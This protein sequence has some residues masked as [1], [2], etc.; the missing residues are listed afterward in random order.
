MAILKNCELW[1]VKCDPANPD[2]KFEKKGMWTVQLRTTDPTQRK[3]WREL[4]LKTKLQTKRN[5]EDEDVPVLTPEGKKQWQVILQKRCFNA[6]GQETEPV[7]VV[8]GQLNDID[9]RTVGNGSVGNVR[10]FQYPSKKNEG[11]MVSMLMAIQV[12]KLKVYEPR[13]AEDSFDFEETE[14]INPS[15]GSDS[16]E[17]EEESVKKDESEDDEDDDIPFEG[18]RTPPKPS[19]KP[20][21]RP[22]VASKSTAP[23]TADTHPED[24]F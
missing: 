15:K 24:A 17:E 8:D 23:K 5:E 9:P 18:G 20:S 4:G 19:P 22:T 10:I 7:K 6:K 14:I 16:F 13:S 3:Q 1:W 2:R 11:E 21:P 12:T